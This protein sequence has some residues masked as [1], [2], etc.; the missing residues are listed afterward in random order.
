[1]RELYLNIFFSFFIIIFLFL[2]GRG[3][4]SLPLYFQF[5]PSDSVS[6]VHKMKQMKGQETFKKILSIIIY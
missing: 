4:G 3:T 5:L 6:A 1:M 2:W